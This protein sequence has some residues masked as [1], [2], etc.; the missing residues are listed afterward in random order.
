MRLRRGA[1][2]AVLFAVIGVTA[3]ARAQVHL[4]WRASVRLTGAYTQ[5]ISDAPFPTAQTF[6]GPL[7]GLSPSIVALLD[8]LRTENTLTYAFALTVPFA[9]QTAT[10]SAPVSYSNRLNYMGHY[11]FNEITSGTLGAGVT[12][13]PL[14]ALDPTSDPTAAPIQSVPSGTAYMLSANAS[15][16]IVRQLTE[17]TSFSQAGAFLYGNPIDPSSEPA[18]TYSIQNSFTVTRSFSR[19]SLGGTLTTQANYFTAA[20]GPAPLLTTTPGSSA[21]VNT[22]TANYSHPF[23]QAFSGTVTAGVTQ[24]L[25]PGATTFMEV[26]PT[27]TLALT[28]NFNL[29]TATLNYAHQAMPNLIT[30]TVN[31]VDMASMRFSLPFGVTGLTALGTAGY[32]RSMPLTAA[33]T[34]VSATTANALAVANTILADVALN[35]QPRQVETLTFGVRGQLTRQWSSGDVTD[36]ATALTNDLTRYTISVNVTYSY[37]NA[38]AALVRPSFT[39]LYS[40]QAPAPADI[41]STDRFFSAPVGGAAPAEAPPKPAKSP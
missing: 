24:T 35:F 20:V 13:S 10:T 7:I 36:V 32:S 31:F 41:V 40:V 17:L 2:T 39:P 28:Y 33:N 19:D 12:L 34:D 30:G 14:N 5:T 37:P 29:A 8:T 15:E 25:S 3:P 26:Q 38:N 9:R 27:G 21:Y 4:S 18:H 6:A 16:G 11:A 1:A 23:T 22:L